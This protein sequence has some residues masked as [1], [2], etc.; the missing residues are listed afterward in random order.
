[1]HLQFFLLPNIILIF[2]TLKNI[3]TKYT[4]TCAY[5]YEPLYPYYAP[6]PLVRKGINNDVL[7]E[8]FLLYGFYSY[9]FPERNTSTPS[10][11]KS[12]APTDFW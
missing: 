12:S 4:C 9:F 7:N 2:I 10:H 1:M 8:Y 6:N 3:A 5:K 11:H